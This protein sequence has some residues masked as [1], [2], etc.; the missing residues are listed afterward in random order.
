MV[1]VGVRLETPPWTPGLANAQWLLS[2][3]WPACTDAETYSRKRSF[4]AMLCAFYK[5][6][7]FF[8]ASA[9]KL[10]TQTATPTQQP[11]PYPVAA[12]EWEPPARQ[13]GGSRFSGAEPL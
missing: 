12:A 1:V 5:F 11:N 6:G 3:S 2:Q 4:T 8:S 10:P 13:Q 7:L 9:R